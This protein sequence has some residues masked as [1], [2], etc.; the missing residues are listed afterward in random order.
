[1][2]TYTATRERALDHRKL[3]SSDQILSLRAIP[4][5][6]RSDENGWRSAGQRSGALSAISTRL[7]FHSH[8]HVEPKPDVHGPLGLNLLY[9]PSEPRVDFVFIHGLGG[10]SQK[11]WSYSSEPGMFWPKDW[12]PNEVGFRH[13]RLHSYGYNSDWTTKKASPLTIHD[14][15]QALLADLYNSPYL[16]KNGDTPI[17][18]VAH[19]MGG[20]VAKKA[21][22]LATRD[23]IYKDIARR[24][25]TMFFLGTPHRGADSA[26]TAKVQINDEFRHVCENIHI[27][28]FTEAIPTKVGLPKEHVQY[29][30]ADHRNICKFDTPINP[31]YM[32]LQRAFLATIEDMASDLSFRR[33]DEYRSQM[34]KVAALLRVDQRPDAVLLATNEKQHPG[35]CQWLTESQAF[36][37]WVDNPVDG[38]EELGPLEDPLEGEKRPKILWLDGRPGTGKSV[39]A[40][41]VIR[42]LQSCNLDCSFYFFE[43]KNKSGSTIAAFLRSLAFQMAES[44]FEIRRAVVSMAEDD[45]RINHDD[46][47]MLWTSLFT[48]R[49]LKVEHTRPQYWVIDAVDECSS[50]GMPALVSMLSN[51]D[52]KSPV[53]VFM[54]SRPGGQLGRLL[55]LERTEFTEMTTGQEGSLRDIELLVRARCPGASDAGHY[56]DLVTDVLAKCN[57]IFLSPEM[58]MFYS[59]IIATIVESPSFELAKCILKW[60][61]CSPEPLHFEELAEAVK[62]D[63]G[64]TLTASGGQLETMTGHLVYVDNQLAE[65]CL[66]VLCGTEFAPPR[67]R[68]KGMTAKNTV[69]SALADYAALNFSYHL[70]HGSSAADGPLILLN[71]FLRSNVLTWIEKTASTRNLWTLQL[72]AQRLKAYLGRRA[73]YQSL[74]S[75]ESQTVARW[76]AD[77][78]HI[79]AA[80][81]SSLLTSPSSIYFLIPHFCPPKSIIQELFAKPTRQLRI[82]GPLEEDWNDRLA[83]YLFPEEAS[84]V[85]CCT[86]FLAV[87]LADGG[88]KIYHVAG[89]DSDSSDESDRQPAAWLPSEWIRL[90]PGHRLAALA[91][92]NASVLIWDLS[93]VE[94]IGKFEKEGF[95]D[96]YASPQTLDMI[97]NPVPELELLAI[98]YKDGDIVTCNPWTLEQVN[99]CHLQVYL[100]ALAATSDGR[101]LAGAT[102]D[103]GI[104]LFLFETLQP[105]YQIGRSDNNLRIHDMVFSADNLRFFDIRGQCCTVWEPFILV[106]KDESDDNSSEAQSEEVITLESPVSR[107]HVFEWGRAI[108]VIE[109]AAS[110]NFVMVGRQ[111]GT[112]DICEVS[113]GAVLD[114]LKLHDSFTEIE[115]IDWDDETRS[116]LSVDTTGRYILTRLSVVGQG[117]TKVQT[118][119]LL[120]C[121]EPASIRQALI[122]PRS[123]SLLICTESS[124]KIIGLDGK[125]A[126]HLFEWDSLKRPLQTNGVS[127]LASEFPTQASSHPWIGGAGSGYVA[128]C[129]FQSSARTST[130]FALETSKITSETQDISLQMLRTGSLNVQAVLGCTRSKLFILDT[131]GWVCSVGLKN[132]SKATQYTRHFFIP[133]TWRAGGGIVIKA[134]SKTA[135]AFGRGEQL[136]IL[137]GFLELEEAVAF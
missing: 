27:W 29:I 23:P 137:H 56:H 17:V 71:K 61:I 105:I 20:L 39:A 32:V 45:I 30:E 112:I 53:R 136:I 132:L 55:S 92:R 81:H 102:D 54:T 95:E 8:N 44:N 96:V 83:C 111:D 113:T 33:R 82:A 87:G 106:P 35:S 90:D 97:F 107:A 103:G 72:T 46:H 98:T 85:A 14:F 28:S 94:Q 84:A 22:L 62:L 93:S 41:H 115:H 89:S 78:Y 129:V 100:I 3:E 25:H 31:N 43:H 128:Q 133:L 122:G 6:R 12:L 21:Y 76:A 88:I 109:H 69:F 7:S 13:V 77:I 49:I 123:E 101:V 2:L 64:R 11:T 26:H 37:E 121:R 58:D 15:G 18:F 57:G 108:T 110:G 117:S 130:I 50:K 52:Y 99:K 68:R 91:Y 1:M 75:V 116:L 124:A 66:S 24:I 67:M 104:Y 80:F 127:L 48:E 120:D 38:W 34:K 86:R 79:V 125:N 59:R 60:A 65:V 73:K 118:S 131:N 4:P 70:M 119:C 9:E 134:I 42:Y 40:G 114:K 16:R 51:L 74:A 135:V 47:H 5:R 63:I 10:G 19:S 126:V 36:Q